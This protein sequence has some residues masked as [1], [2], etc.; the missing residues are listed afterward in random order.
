VKQHERISIAGLHQQLLELYAPPSVLV[1]AQ[2]EII[3]VSRNAGR[4]LQITG[5][6]SLNLLNAVRPELRLELRGALYSA[7]Q[8]G[9]TVQV[10]GLKVRVGDNEETIDIVVKPA[11]GEVEAARGFLLVFFQPPGSV[12]QSPAISLKAASEPIALHLEEELLQTRSHLRQLSEQY[13][14]QTEEF[15]ASNEELQAINEELR[16]A[17]EELET[18]K[19]ELQSVN[20]ELTTVNQE[21]KIKIEELS[22]ANNDFLNLINA[23][24]IGTIFLDRSFSVNLFTP[25]ARSIFNLKTADYGRPLTDITSRISGGGI[26]AE[27]ELVMASL[28]PAE[29]EVET[30]DGHTYLMRVLPYR[31]AEDH[32]N[33]VVITFIDITERKG[34]EEAL[35][36]SEEQIRAMFNQAR[37]GVMQTDLAGRF[38]M[39]NRRVCAMLGYTEK[40]LLSKNVQDIIHLD[41]LPKKEQLLG[42]L[43]K[44]GQAFEAELR[45]I[46]KNGSIIWFH[47]SAT[48]IHDR[49]GD[50]RSI[51]SIVVDVTNQKISEQ[52]KDEFIAIASHELKTP[53]TS[54]KAYTEILLDRLAQQGD[55]ESEKILRR[56]DGQIERMW[57]LIR[58]LL[59]TERITTGTFT[60]HKDPFDLTATIKEVV[61]TMQL[62]APKHKLQT[63]LS[64]LPAFNGD[65]ERIE[66]VLINL[67]DNAIKYAAGTSMIK[68]SSAV[69]DGEIHICVQDFGKGLTEEAMANVFQRF[70][71]VENTANNDSLGLGL[72][73]SMEIAKLHGGTI[74]V[75]STQGSGATFCLVLPR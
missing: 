65:K 61:D 69:T 16:S 63:E 37:A 64:P 57:G 46:R 7:S 52:Q 44:D 33:G 73:I 32:I 75:K 67:L 4:Y 31:T 38:T 34:A 66:E 23:T 70:Y 6:P 11:P 21:L 58:E 13:E 9:T 62:I 74:K 20:E 56:L 41:D 15:K 19:E 25:A 45:Y 55:K 26:M 39:V 59:D 50:A 72:Y 3:H 71:R 36:A 29:R 14:V 47:N 28:Q 5:E 68:I 40:E 30:L 18:S 53:V 43:I 24:N 17:A 54:I 27:L 48:F 1:N 2:H 51:L 22:H 8:T 60:I 49:N 42:Q 12:P 35:R 10:A